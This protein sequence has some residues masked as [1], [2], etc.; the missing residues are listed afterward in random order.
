MHGL[1]VGD[2]KLGPMLCVRLREPF[3]SVLEANDLEARFD[4]GD[5]GRRDDAVDAGCRTAS[6]QNAQSSFFY[7][8]VQFQV[9]CFMSVFEQSYCSSRDFQ[10]PTVCTQTSLRVKNELFT[11]H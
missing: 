4:A 2:G 6:D 9:Q 5:G 11:K 10:H 3:E 1:H 8:R 7:V